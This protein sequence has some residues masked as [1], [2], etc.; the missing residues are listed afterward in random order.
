MDGVDAERVLAE[1]DNY[2]RKGKALLPLR[3]VFTQNDAFQSAD[4]PMVNMRAKE[5]ERAAQMFAKK[6]LEPDAG[7][8]GEDMF[9][10]AKEFH[11]SNKQVANILSNTDTP[12]SQPTSSVAASAVQ[13]AK[14]GD[15][16]DIDIDADDLLDA[17]DV[18]PEEVK[19]SVNEESSSDIFVPPSQGADQLAIAAKKHPLVAG[20]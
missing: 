19:E 12:A 14:W 8:D 16:D 13:N 10:D 15:E 20:L 3:P 2:S 17:N 7:N 1:A 4:W 11:T 6:K 18:A 9:F 5:A